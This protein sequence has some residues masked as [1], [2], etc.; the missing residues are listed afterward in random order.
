M[1]RNKNDSNLIR[2]DTFLYRIKMFFTNLFSFHLNKKEVIVDSNV[3][4]NN[5][6]EPLENDKKTNFVEQL[7][8]EDES[9]IQ[10]LVRLLKNNTISVEEL[11]K[12]QKS[13]VILFLEEDISS[14]KFKL[15][16]IKNK[17]IY[18]KLQ[19][20]SGDDNIDLVLDNINKEDKTSFIE[21]LKKEINIKKEKLNKLKSNINIT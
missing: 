14:K 16:D 11:T 8:V 4:D 15:E 17:K 7:K 2:T 21:Y 20:V 19:K 13:D 9:Q 18:D 5:I 10:K 1:E 3:L 6:V 12:K